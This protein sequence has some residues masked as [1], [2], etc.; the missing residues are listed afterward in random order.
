VVL[1]RRN[2]KQVWINLEWAGRASHKMPPFVLEV[3]AVKDKANKLAEL[4]SMSISAGAGEE[5]FSSQSCQLELADGQEAQ[6]RLKIGG[7]ERLSPVY[8]P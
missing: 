1:Q 8:Q 5:A 7:R 4:N 3:F 2:S 6:V